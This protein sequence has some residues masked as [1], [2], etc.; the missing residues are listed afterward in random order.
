MTAL[1]RVHRRL[2]EAERLRSFVPAV[3]DVDREHCMRMLTAEDGDLEAA[4]TVACSLQENIQKLN[5]QCVQASS[6]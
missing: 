6:C 3:G 4:H 5:T 1:F 2:L